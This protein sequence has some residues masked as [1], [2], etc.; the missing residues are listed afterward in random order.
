MGIPSWRIAFGLRSCRA[1]KR[2]AFARSS[3]VEID[4]PFPEPASGGERFFHSQ[5]CIDPK[6]QRATTPWLKGGKAIGKAAKGKQQSWQEKGADKWMDVL[7]NTIIQ[8]MPASGGKPAP[9]SNRMMKHFR[10]QARVFA[11]P[12]LFVE[13]GN[14]YSAKTLYE[15]YMAARIIVHKR[16]RGCSAPVRQGAAQE[17]HLQTGRYGF[18]R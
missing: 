4:E 3:Q 2:I 9:G 18:G 16:T 7:A 12:E 17:R 5:F 8:P 1:F 15:Y 14:A 6:D 13:F 10:R 11:L